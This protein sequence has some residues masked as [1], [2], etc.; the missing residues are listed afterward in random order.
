MLNRCLDDAIP[1]QWHHHPEYELTLTLNSEGQRFIGDHVGEYGDGDLVLVGPNLPHT[2]S[3]RRKINEGRPHVALVFW[4]R[5]AWIDSFVGSAVELNVVESLFMRAAS[6]LAFP[7]DVGRAIRPRFEAVFT[8]AP[9]QRLVQV[10]GIL[11]ELAAETAVQPLATTVP[12]TSAGNHTR[13]DRVLHHLHQHYDSPIR[14]GDLAELAALSQSGLHRLFAN[15]TR[16]TVSDYIARLR[17]GDACARLSATDQPIGHIAVE[18]GYNNLANFNRQFL[19]LRQ[20]TPRQY[21]ASFRR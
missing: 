20:M 8:L 2:W 5:R 13:L 10:L 6:G 9:G 21:R 19:S 4:F 14:I 17:V 12:L 7:A 15:H 11:L 18:V 1:F 16:T 3:S